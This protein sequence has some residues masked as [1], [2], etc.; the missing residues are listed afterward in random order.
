VGTHFIWCKF[1]IRLAAVDRQLEVS[2]LQFNRLVQPTF[3]VDEQ[4]PGASEARSSTKAGA[5]FPRA[6]LKASMLNQHC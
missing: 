6:S 1:E 3:L 5:G 2:W 4:C